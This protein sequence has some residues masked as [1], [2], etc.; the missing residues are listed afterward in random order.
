MKSEKLLTYISLFSCAGIGC[1]G[2]KKAGFK[3]IATNEIITRRLQIQKFNNKCEREEGY[4]D[5][6]ITLPETKQ[7]I[8]NEINWWKE[9]KGI[10]DVDVL[11]AT[12]PCQG[13]SV[14]NHKKNANDLNR[15][16][17]VVESI[18]MVCNIK[19]KMFLFENVP[20]FMNTL[21][22]LK[23]GD[24][25]PIKKAIKQ[26]LF[27]DYLYYYDTINFKN[28]GS[29]SSRT[30]TLVIGVRKD[31]A[32]NISP[33][34]L[35]P[36]RKEEK[37]LRE[38]IGDLPNL[39]NM[40]EIDPTDI[41]HSF[42]PYPTYMRE[43]ISDIGEGCSAFDNIDQ[44]KRPYKIDKNGDHI[45][46][47]NKT[48]GKYTRQV[49]NKVAASV[50]T[51]NDQL[52]SQNTIHPDDDRV[53]SIR[54]LML[55]MTIPND[56]KWSNIDFDKL[57][58]LPVLEKQKF[59]KKEETNIRQCIGESV[60]T[61]IFQYIAE[62]MKQFLIATQMSDSEINS[63]IKEKNLSDS[64][65]L[66]KFVKSNFVRKQSRINVATI[67][68]ISELS[69][70]KRTEHAAYYTEKET[71]TEIFQHLPIIDKDEIHILE[72]SVGSGNFIPFIIKKYSY[73]KKLFIDVI[74]IDE[75]AIKVFRE[76]KRYIDKPKNVKISI[77][78]TDFLKY[79]TKIHY[80]LVVGNPPFI[81]LTEAKGVKTYQ[82]KYSDSLA[83]NTAAFFIY[84]SMEISDNIALVLPKNF[85]CNNDYNNLRSILAKKKISSII[86]FGHKGFKGVR[87][88]TIMLC[89]NTQR[90]GTKVEVV[91]PLRN[92]DSIQMQTY[93]TDSNLPTWVIY[94][95]K[96]F[97]TVLEKK[98]FGVFEVFR[99]RQITKTTTLNGN[100][101]WV[102]KSKNINRSGNKIEHIANYD[103]Y[104][105]KK[106]LEKLNIYK[107]LENDSVYLVPNMTYYPRMIKKPK[108]IVTNGSVAIFTPKEGIN[109]TSTD[110]KYIASKEFEEFYRVARNYANRSLNIDS[111]TIYYFCIDKKEM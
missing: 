24:I 20:A 16:S 12:P 79:S 111:N 100:N 33:I 107:Y 98:Q 32:K 47:V 4:I 44:D 37:T 75:N 58:A 25:V 40:N 6:D 26:F 43:W 14:F 23:N 51:R 49:W 95:N 104:I 22:Q 106:E 97:D 76:I 35:F 38:I 85:L 93:I 5:G 9:N 50:H 63:L 53:F 89:L 41:Y 11:I 101:I 55:M 90:R 2:F 77:H 74:D 92:Y 48:G 108:G 87:I 103:T 10:S 68:R 59:L 99:D 1:Y 60:P 61:A 52:A 46:N 105:S 45:P 78:K 34:E 91:S 109:I 64:E 62:L 42:R 36:N 19:P 67:S 82:Q 110:L 57:N 94:R 18:E 71:L 21:C 70:S 29:N 3:C 83:K 86:D 27:N 39:Q 13:M 81:L 73:A 65:S 69:N 88:E 54:E 96:F 30:R 8:S 80:D 15:N 7:K 102:V 84:K 31:I 28:Y 17:L 56:F 66:V 72:P